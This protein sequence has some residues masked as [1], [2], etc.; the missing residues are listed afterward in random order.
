MLMMHLSRLSE[1]IILWCSQEFR[2]IELDDTYATGFV[3]SEREPFHNREKPHHIT[4]YASGFTADQLRHVG[5]LSRL[6]EEII[7]WCSQEFRF[8]ELDD[9]YATGS[10]MMPQCCRLKTRE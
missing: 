3:V 9:T 7:L 6:S 10:S 5:V 2:F 8:I 4:V 1:E